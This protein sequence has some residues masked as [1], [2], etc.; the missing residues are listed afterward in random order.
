MTPPGF[1]PNFLFLC[2]RWWGSPLRGRVPIGWTLSPALYSLAPPVMHHI[3]S[4]ATP[5]DT[6]VAAPSG[7]GYIY[8][9]LT[10]GSPGG[11]EKLR[12]F[13]DVTAAYMDIT[14]M[15]LLNVL[16]WRY[17]QDAADVMV[18]SYRVARGRIE[19]E[20][21]EEEQGIVSSGIEGVLWL[22]KVI[23]RSFHIAQI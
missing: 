16:G 3:Y 14:G 17:S 7:L 13:A 9:D 1:V 5:N 12:Q 6:F 21:Q 18:E 15:Q 20:Q 8:P 10:I 19:G 22:S 2:C 23:L 11:R 4:T